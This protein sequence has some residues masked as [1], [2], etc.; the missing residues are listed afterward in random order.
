MAQ[1][2]EQEEL[3]EVLQLRTLQQLQELSLQ[4][5]KSTQP[6]LVDPHATPM[7]VTRSAPVAL[8]A[9]AATVKSP[10]P[11][12]KRRKPPNTG[13]GKCMDWNGTFQ[14]ILWVNEGDD[15]SLIDRYHALKDL[16]HD[17]NHAARTYAT[18]IIE[19]SFSPL[20]IML[21]NVD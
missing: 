11:K 12:G 13:Y 6:K 7:K 14:D 2:D 9:S 20:G 17:F 5:I 4:L 8:A 10:S 19:G 3:K 16:A 15:R 18:I 21:I 1:S